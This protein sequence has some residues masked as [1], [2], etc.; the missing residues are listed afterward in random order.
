VDLTDS[1]MTGLRLVDPVQ[2]RPWHRGL[3]LL[4]RLGSWLFGSVY[5]TGA[6]A[7]V[8][9]RDGSVLMVK[10]R[11]RRGWGL[12]GGFLKR[13]EQPVNTLRRELLEETGL[14]I[15]AERPHE[16][17]VQRKRRHI[18][19]LFVVRLT[20]EQEAI[21]RARYEISHASWHRLD[22]LPPL[23]PEA[24]EALQRLAGL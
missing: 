18:D 3:M 23:Q 22:D 17:Y 11:Y 21:P 14:A 9:R 6:L 1:G 4:V 13:G 10:P 2:D 16:V 15:D 8:F 12:P 7:V 20:S 5:T 24:H 19:H